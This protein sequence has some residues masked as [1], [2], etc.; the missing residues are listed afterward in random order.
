MDS[1]LILF[2]WGSLCAAD[3]SQLTGSLLKAQQDVCCPHS[4]IESRVRPTNSHKEELVVDGALRFVPVATV[5]VY[6]VVVV[7]YR[8]PLDGAKT[9]ANAKRLT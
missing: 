9:Y 6:Q 7:H 2:S 4:Q 5:G 8:V 1:I 3:T